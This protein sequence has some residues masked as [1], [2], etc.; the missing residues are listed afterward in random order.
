MPKYTCLV[1]FTFCL[2]TLDSRNTLDSNP[3]L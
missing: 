3:R 1:P 2:N